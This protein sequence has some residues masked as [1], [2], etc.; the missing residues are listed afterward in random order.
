MLAQT[1]TE[2]PSRKLGL[3]MST[4]LVIGN[5]IGS[6]IFLLPSSLAPYGGI[7][8]VG[9][10]VTAVGAIC[11][12]LVFAKLAAWVPR[13]GGP[14]AY[15][16]L[17]FGDFA[18]F[19]IAWGY[20]IAIWVGNAAIA[21]ACVSYLEVFIPALR[22]NVLLAGIG[23]IALVWLFTWINCL[24]VKE[25]GVTQLLTTI[26]KIV[27]LVAI[28]TMGLFWLNPSHFVPF[29][30]SGESAFSAV[31]SVAALTLWSFIGLESATVPAGDVENPARTIPRAT[32]L[33]TLVTALV[34]ILGTVAVMGVIPQG[35]LANSGAPFADAARVMW[36]DW[37]YYA[38]G[39]GAV[40]SCAGALNGWTLL[41]GQ[42]PMAAAGDRLFP[43]KF[44]RLSPRGVPAFSVIISSVLITLL[45]LLNYSGSRS[46]VEIFNFVILLATLTTVIPYVFCSI[47][48]FII[49]L[50]D[51]THLGGRRR[52]RGSGV[53][54][55]IAFLY[56]VWAVYGS[57]AETVLYGFI[58][59]LFGIPVYVWLVKEQQEREH[60]AQTQSSDESHGI[61][62]TF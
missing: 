52:F 17:G 33:G 12:A 10:L 58:L 21:I 55:A 20:W 2:N 30:P 29:N 60:N 24:G 50:R 46:L 32:I 3:W 43:Q 40:V 44:G 26:V 22:G 34:Y 6:G 7:S 31:S 8:L 36:G 11:L 19:W 13:A 37:A 62:P 54:A 23:A 49:F 4:A 38:V 35:T 15:T 28:A 1:E 45:L 51:P 53:V 14:Y 25:V 39:F 48:E 5:M 61:E 27:P 18:G 9:W 41:Q 56:S 16:R 59:L 57:G 47:A 42:I